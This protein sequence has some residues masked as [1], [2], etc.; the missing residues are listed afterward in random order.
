M[1]SGS[2]EVLNITNPVSTPD[3]DVRL[4]EFEERMKCAL[5]ESTKLQQ[6][7]MTRI[8]QF[9][10]QCQVIVL[11]FF[12]TTIFFLKFYFCFFDEYINIFVKL[13]INSSK[14]FIQIENYFH[15][16]GLV[17][18]LKCFL[19]LRFFKFGLKS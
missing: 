7:Q 1:D 9:Q 3:E 6:V 4:K 2:L 13:K 18:Y 10:R 17:F 5:E 14:F 19:R 11:F 15:S 12:Y 8:D 16:L